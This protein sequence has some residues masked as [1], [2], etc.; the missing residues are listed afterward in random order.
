MQT[1][2]SLRAYR[3]QLWLQQR[4]EL[5]NDENIEDVVGFC[6]RS[7]YVLLERALGLRSRARVLGL[8][9]SS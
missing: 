7:W 9:G 8:L 2:W 1:A 3:W 6:V 4:V 5:K